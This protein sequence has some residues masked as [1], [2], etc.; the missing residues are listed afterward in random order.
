M[1]E[2]GPMRDAL[3]LRHDRTASVLRAFGLSPLVA[4]A[5][6]ASALAAVTE[7]EPNGSLNAAQAV[8][9]PLLAAAFPPAGA[10][11]L[12]SAELAAGDVDYFAVD[13]AAGEFFSAAVATDDEGALADPALAL[14][15]PGG[16]RVLVDDDAGP[17]F[18]PALRRRVAQS[19]TWTIGVTGFG[20][21]DFDGA[22]H[23]E[24]FDYRLV[25]SVTTEPPNFPEPD[26]DT[27]GSFAN[28]DPVPIG[29]GDFDASAPGG[30]AVVTGTLAP[31]DV[32]YYNV[33][34]A[35]GRELV[36]AVYDDLAGASAD[37]LL[38][39]LSASD[40]VASRDDDAGPGFLAAE[41]GTTA[42]AA[43][44]SLTLAV[45]GFGDADLDGTH[46]EELTYQLVVALGPG[47]GLTCDVDGDDFVDRSDLDAIFAARGQPASGQGDARD[48]D[49]DGQITV[50]DGRICSNRCSRA[51]CLP[52]PVA[53]AC[54]LGAELTL[55]V[56]GAAALRGRGSRRHLEDL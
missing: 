52:R 30:V 8:G 26:P 29:G 18:L 7:T 48:A 23:A 51:H 53:P 35:P 12:V 2:G 31:G 4:A 36:A 16:V 38:A 39:V 14:F 10:G 1:Q 49:A 11:A 46:G 22:G 45:T 9:A 27:N 43:A 44:T 33:P 41:G 47:A 21:A 6:A 40:T 28:A 34:L 54:G 25:L 3:R 42:P 20:D 37:P 50:L 15:D 5:V 17:G 24:A 19:G 32:D 55:L 13:L 56:A